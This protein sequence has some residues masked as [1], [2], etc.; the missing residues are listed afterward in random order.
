MD[1]LTRGIK[2]LNELNKPYSPKLKK[3][4]A[5]IVKA[6]AE[7]LLAESAIT[8]KQIGN[9]NWVEGT[10][11]EYKYQAKIYTEPSDYGIDNGHVSKLCITLNGDSWANTVVNYDRGWDIGKGKKKIYRPLVAELNTFAKSDKFVI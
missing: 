1:N 6:H 7:Q 3:A 11:G 2:M 4:I 5:E 10:Y 9:G 8:I